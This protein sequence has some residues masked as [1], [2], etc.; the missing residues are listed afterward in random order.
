MGDRGFES[1]SLQRR[2]RCEPDF[3]MFDTR[4]R[5][6]QCGRQS[7]L[8]MRQS[9]ERLCHANVVG[10]DAYGHGYVLADQSGRYP[11]TEW[12]RVAIGL[13]RQHNADRVHSN[14]CYG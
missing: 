14:S 11:P 3:L 10:I 7:P 5:W 2:V 8:G 4:Y 1:V 9:P 12:A 6:K 13:Y